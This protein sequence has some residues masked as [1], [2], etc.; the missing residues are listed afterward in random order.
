[1]NKKELREKLG[2]SSVAEI[3][4]ILK[5]SGKDYQSQEVSDQ[6]AAF[7]ESVYVLTKQGVPVADAISLTQGYGGLDLV[8]SSKEHYLALANQLKEKLKLDGEE[9]WTAYYEFLPEVIKSAEVLE[10]P[11]V[12]GAREKASAQILRMFNSQENPDLNQNKEFFFSEIRKRIKQQNIKY[13][14]EKAENFVPPQEVVA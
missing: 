7:V 1:M 11:A 2:A 8:D 9:F 14:K 3:S 6:D 13:H 4:N 5:E 10:S 12:Q